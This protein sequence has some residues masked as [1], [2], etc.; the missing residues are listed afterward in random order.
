[1]GRILTFPALK[2]NKKVMGMIKLSICMGSACYMKGAP[3]IV[4][5]LKKNLEKYEL[6]DFVELSGAFCLGPCLE[7]VV[8]KLQDK[9]FKKLNPENIQ[10]KFEK[11]I[12][13]TILEYKIKS[14]EGRI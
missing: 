9:L 11:E 3:K 5:V 4:E 6:E 7:G 2:N 1:M 10:E 12:Y 14:I 8:V 13:P